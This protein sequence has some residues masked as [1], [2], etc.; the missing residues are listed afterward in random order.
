MPNG[1][2]LM[3]ILMHHDDEWDLKLVKGDDSGWVEVSEKE[4]NSIRV[5][6]NFSLHVDKE[7]K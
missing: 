4:Y 7:N 3:P 2:T 6:D 1:K 5:G